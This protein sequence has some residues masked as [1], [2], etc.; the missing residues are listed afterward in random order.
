MIV[1]DE[2]HKL[3]NPKSKTARAFMEFKFGCRI[4]L[5]G[6]PL[7]NKLE[8]MWSLLNWCNQN[9]LE[10]LSGFKAFYC[11][12]ILNG[13]KFDATSS[14]VAEGRDLA[15]RLK[16]YVDTVMLRRT[17]KIIANELPR[18]EDRVVFCP[19]SPMQREV[20]Q[21]LLDSEDFRLVIEKDNLCSC[22]S[23][24]TQ[25]KCCFGMNSLGEPVDKLILKG[26]SALRSISNH[27]ALL[28]PSQEDDEAQYER[29]AKLTKIMFPKDWKMKK[30]NFLE[31]SNIENCGKWTILRGMLL[32][33]RRERKKVLL[34]SYSARLLNMLEKLMISENWEFKR[35]D[36]STSVPDRLPMCDEFNKSES[37]FVFLISTRAGGL[38]LNLVSSNTVVI[39]DPSWNPA[40][41]L[42]AQDRAFR[43][44]Q[45]K[46]VKVYRLIAAG[47]IE[48][49]VYGRQIYKQQ[50]SNIATEAS[51]ERRLFNGVQGDKHNKGDLFGY[52]NLYTLHNNSDVQTKALISRNEI[53][54][55]MFG[56]NED[57]GTD[58]EGD[59]S[60]LH[61]L[62]DYSDDEAKFQPQGED[63]GLGLKRLA[64]RLFE[65]KE[66]TV[67]RAKGE[68]SRARDPIGA[69][70]DECGVNYSHANTDFI[71]HSKTEEALAKVAK[72]VMSFHFMFFQEKNCGLSR[73]YDFMRVYVLGGERQ[74]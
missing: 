5:T 49:N 19:L 55:T 15:S 30:S 25:Y 35:L 21:R 38:G 67:R 37:I 13:Q 32:E 47:S 6:T 72:K 34:F 41:D 1:V 40:S 17:K 11:K 56:V 10:T 26:L 74:S 54:E 22:K 58:D 29:K 60:A 50:L 18:K 8:E 48:E 16:Q 36:G 71:G 61:Q 57:D 45:K 31:Y 64:A 2:A 3:K 33:W 24:L 4:A 66:S 23:G 20:Y 65:P 12:P 14:E 44:G 46:D 59:A 53:A 68:S 39:F 7:S 62:R 43:I 42:Q 73:F 63:D 28:F 51:H 52:K 69:I 9:C 27:V 70:L